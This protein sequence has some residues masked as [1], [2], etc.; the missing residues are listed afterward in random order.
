MGPGLRHLAAPAL[1]VTAVVLTGALAA[2]SLREGS[3]SG[4]AWAKERTPDGQPNLQG[5]WTND[6]YTPLE[7]PAEL[8]GKE[9]FTPEEA[10]A[11]VKSRTDR[12]EGQSKDD[13]HYD[14]A[15]WQAENYDKVASR[16]TS[17]IVEP[18]DGKLPP[19]TA[20]GQSQLAHQ[21]G[22]QRATATS[23]S[24][25]QPIARRALHLVGQRRPA[26]GAA[27]LQREHA[28]HPVARLAGHAPRAHARHTNRLLGRPPASGPG[29][30]VDGGPLRGPLGRPDARRRHD[31]LHRQNELPRVA[32]EH[33]P[34]HLREREA[35]RDRAVHA[36]G[37]GHDALR[38]HA[39][40]I[41]TRGRRRGPARWRSA[42]PTS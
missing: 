36:H 2:Q 13:I 24:A 11:F 26:D 22:T 9:F 8:G 20:L 42:V 16:R 28:V 39:S 15:I 29:R 31:E 35:A 5:Y 25:Q 27:D 12:L 33:A 38:V 30:S 23:D 40:R 6:T 21:K 4:D 19:L 32:G 37:R 34:G 1:L 10:A 14:D 17:I 7:R 18:R 41:P 3:I